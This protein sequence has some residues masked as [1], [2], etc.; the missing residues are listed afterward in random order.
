MDSRDSTVQL[1]VHKARRNVTS[2]SLH[3]RTLKLSP[4]ENLHTDAKQYTIIPNLYPVWIQHEYF[5]VYKCGENLSHSVMVVFESASGLLV[6]WKTLRTSSPCLTSRSK[7]VKTEITT[8][9]NLSA[10]ESLQLLLLYIQRSGHISSLCMERTR[11]NP[12]QKCRNDKD[13]VRFSRQKWHRTEFTV[14]NKCKTLQLSVSRNSKPDLCELLRKRKS[15]VFGWKLVFSCEDTHKCKQWHRTG[16]ENDDLNDPLSPFS[17]NFVFG[18]SEVL[19][20]SITPKN[21]VSCLDISVSRDLCCRLCIVWEYQNSKT[22]TFLDSVY[23]CVCPTYTNRFWNSKGIDCSCWHTHRAVLWTGWRFV[24]RRNNTSTKLDFLCVLVQKCRN[25]E[26]SQMCQP[27]V[28]IQSYTQWYDRKGRTTSTACSVQKGETGD[29][30]RIVDAAICL[31]TSVG[32]SPVFCSHHWPPCGSDKWHQ[33]ATNA[34]FCQS[35]S[36]YLWVCLHLDLPLTL[37]RIRVSRGKPFS[38]GFCVA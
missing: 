27:A 24:E 23:R 17:G 10:C 12:F 19:Q 9:D 31:E 30:R 4:K 13:N 25:H 15:S 37:F 26:M 7:I 1:R 28:A 21:S 20:D 2:F 16:K 6:G 3:T 32:N 35:P 34:I 33:N 18:A 11:T 36:T 38:A 5:S 14:R 29:T 22:F 8:S